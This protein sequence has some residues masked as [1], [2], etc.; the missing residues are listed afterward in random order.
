MRSPIRHTT[1]SI[2]AVVS[3][4]RIVVVNAARAQRG[5]ISTLGCWTQPSIPIETWFH[6]LL[7]EITNFGGASDGNL[8]S[9]DRANDSISNQLA[10]DT[11]FFR[12][13]LHAAGLKNAFVVSHGIDHASG[14]LDGLAKRF[15]AVDIFL[16]FRRI[17][18]HQGMPM[19]RGCNTDRIN[20]VTLQQFLVINVVL[21]S[22][23]SSGWILIGIMAFHT[24]TCILAS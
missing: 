23:E 5:V 19:I 4:R 8:H 9:G 15:F 22:T 11:E 16:G 1:A 20:V 14:F 21:T 18:R 3:P 17:R 12:R 10:S 7:R 6:G 24:L 13:P 2:F